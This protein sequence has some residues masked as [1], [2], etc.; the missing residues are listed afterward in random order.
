MRREVV[1]VLRHPAGGCRV[2][3]EVSTSSTAPEPPAGARTHRRTV[4]VGLLADPGLPT[5]VARRMAEDL[6]DVLAAQVSDAVDWAMEIVDEPF[7]IATSYHRV[8]D[9]ARSRV[10][11][12]DWDIAICITDIPM[13]TGNGIVVADV[14]LQDR[15]ALVSLP[16]LGG[17]W[18]RHRMRVLAV[19][20]IE[21]LVPHLDPALHDGALAD[22]TLTDGGVPPRE[23]PS[24]PHLARRVAP[25]DRDVDIELV[26]SRRSGMLRLLA[27]TVRAN[28]PWQLVVGLSTALAGAA[29]GSAFAILYSA[30]WTLGT[31]LEP[32]RLAAGT[33]ASIAVLVVWLIAGHGLWQRGRRRLRRLDDL[34]NIATLLTVV[35]GVLVFYL[36][37]FV[38]N[39]CAAALII[40]PQYFGEVVGHPVDWTDYLRVALMA[41]GMGTVAGAVGSGL[42][43]DATVRKAAYSTREQQRRAGFGA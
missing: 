31:V 10:G 26:T 4:V 35:S 25:L 17:F 6:P 29:A 19:E 21:E 3:G 27:G 12:T 14:S 40:P 13:A 7:E 41:S 36:A 34:L 32:W 33:L 28:Q 30:I 37:L 15:V 42:E 20:I 43:N 18:L 8:I 11:G 24:I 39:A 38:L 9:K 2:P 23:R 1:G 16:S 22:G 5:N